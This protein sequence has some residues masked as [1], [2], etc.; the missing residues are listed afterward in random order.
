[1]GGPPSTL[2]FLLFVPFFSFIVS[3]PGLSTLYTPSYFSPIMVSQTPSTQTLSPIV[4]SS[5]NALS[6]KQHDNI[7]GWLVNRATLESRRLF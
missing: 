2:A 6:E 3:C 1:M 4:P 7:S 5:I